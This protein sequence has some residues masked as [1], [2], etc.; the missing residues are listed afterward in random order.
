M[1]RFQFDIGDWSTS[2]RFF[3]PEKEGL[4]LRLLTH[5]F[6][7]ERPIPADIARAC[8]E[9]GA[10]TPEHKAIVDALL[11]QFFSLQDDG[12]RHEWCE[13]EMARLRAPAKHGHLREQILA[14]DGHACVYCGATDTDFDIDHVL[15][16]SRGGLNTPENLVTACRTCNRSKGARTPDE[17][18]AARPSW[19]TT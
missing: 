4:Y 10:F 3:T 17:W 7:T 19:R 8:E 15:P 13:R 12:W 9:V 5:Y 6:D 14:R 1:N 11:R 16:R 18:R 2:V